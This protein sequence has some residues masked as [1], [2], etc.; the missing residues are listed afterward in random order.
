MLIA[1]LLQHLETDYLAL[2]EESQQDISSVPLEM[3][4]SSSRRFRERWRSRL[5]TLGRVVRVGQGDTGISG[6]AE[7]VG[8][9]G[10]LVLSRHSRQLRSI[11]WGDLGCPVR[12]LLTFPLA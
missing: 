2:Q 1:R 6:V 12:L 11:T 8:G 3:Y 4:G 7:D 10:E 5:S 9:N